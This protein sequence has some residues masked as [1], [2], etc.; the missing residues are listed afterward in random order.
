MLLRDDRMAA[1]ALMRG[2]LHR[3][4]ATLYLKKL[5]DPAS[6]AQAFEAA[7]DVDRAIALYRQLGQHE[8][9]GD[10]LRRI[11]EEEAAIAE[12]LLAAEKKAATVPARLSL[13][14]AS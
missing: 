5:N 13:P 2:G 4:A 1:N 3:D 7:G 8:K 9:A 14:P 12:Y 6:A 11:G 10:L